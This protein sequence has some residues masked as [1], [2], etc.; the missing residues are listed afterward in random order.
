MK[1]KLH[2]LRVWVVRTIITLLFVLFVW[3]GLF[4][5][6]GF[7]ERGAVNTILNEFKERGTYVKTIDIQGQTVDIYYVYPKYDYEDAESFVFDDS[8]LSKHYIGSSTDIILTT[9]NP[10]RRYGTAIVRDI[11][12]IGA[13]YFFI[14]HATINVTDD[15]SEMI[16]SVGNAIDGNGVRK[17]ENTWIYTEVRYGNDA[18]KILGLRIKNLD[19][20]QKERI[21]TYVTDLIGKEYNYLLPLYV[22]NKYYCTDLI[23]RTLIKEKININYDYFYTTGND[24]IISDETYPIF[25]CER[26]EEGHFEIYYLC[27]E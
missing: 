15:G 4:V 23:S 10:L 3:L 26:I 6:N 24:I 7:L 20:D 25:L 9:R 19:N 16:E 1:Y 12:D 27:E 13:H 18:Q 2:K 5:A 17:V 8:E 11:A 22:K 21:C 14:G